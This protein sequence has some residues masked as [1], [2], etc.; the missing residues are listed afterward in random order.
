MKTA[1]RSTFDT[2]LQPENSNA[3]HKI[4]LGKMKD[5]T[6]FYNGNGAVGFTLAVPETDNSLVHFY[7][8]GV[9]HSDPKKLYR[10]ECLYSRRENFGY[11]DW[12]IRTITDEFTACDSEL[13]QLIGMKS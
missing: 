2:A 1:Y 5:V 9:N 6:L 4:T 13:E 7:R 8:Y 10:S 3:I 11:Q 12:L